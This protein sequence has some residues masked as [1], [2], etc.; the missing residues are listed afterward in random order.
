MLETTT[1]LNSS[2]SSNGGVILKPPVE[3]FKK[4]K[5]SNSSKSSN[6]Q[7]PPRREHF[8]TWFGYNLDSEDFKKFLEF[9]DFKCVKYAFQE[10]ECPKTKRMHL[11]GIL[12]LHKKERDTSFGLPKEIHW[13]AVHNE[14]KATRYCLKS[15]TRSGKQWTKGVPKPLRD[16]MEGLELR[17][18]QRDILDT[19][20]QEPDSRTI[21]W[22]WEPYGNAGKTT[23]AKHL[24][25]KY[26][27]IFVD[28]PGKDLK[29]TLASVLD[30]KGELPV[31]IFGFPKMAEEYIPY[32]AMEQVKDGM[33][34]NSKYEGKMCLFNP[35]HIFVFCNFAPDTTKMSLDRWHVVQIGEI[36]E[37]HPY[38]F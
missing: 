27:A 7:V 1:A 24:C 19:L 37:K 35:P 33:F 22:Y 5:R 28:G 3:T 15:L 31:V 9:L 6:V 21:H 26:G 25:M 8:F 12:K 32:G 2:N 38:D 29:Y 20:A 17:P 16:P 14:D 18:W 36:S 10:E 30:E 13:E 4:Q 34:H 23:F 11:Q